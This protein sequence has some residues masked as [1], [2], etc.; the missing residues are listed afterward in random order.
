[1][2]NPPNPTPPHWA[3]LYDYLDELA[4]AFDQEEDTKIIL[5][6]S[7]IPCPQDREDKEAMASYLLNDLKYLLIHRWEKRRP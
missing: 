4:E 5:S 6:L 7:H 1:M 2:S 3:D